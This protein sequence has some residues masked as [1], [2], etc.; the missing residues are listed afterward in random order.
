[1]I[2]NFP[3]LICRELQGEYIKR[4]K[5]N[6]ARSTG[7]TRGPSP[8]DL[9]L[10]MYL[11]ADKICQNMQR[12]AIS[13]KVHSVFMRFWDMIRVLFICWG[14]TLIDAGE[15]DDSNIYSDDSGYLQ[16][17]YNIWNSH[18]MMKNENDGYLSLSSFNYR[19]TNPLGNVKKIHV[20]VY[21]LTLL[22]GFV[23]CGDLSV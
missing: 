15:L 12:Y 14:T 13:W 10:I 23:I 18:D 7:K 17:I 20:I 21:D 6:N 8:V 19:Y 11:L 4:V 2:F 22:G 9:H 1:M 16:L 3:T 5:W